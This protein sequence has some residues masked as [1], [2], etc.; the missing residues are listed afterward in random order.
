[1]KIATWNVNSVRSR[2]ERL[3]N[4][5]FRHQPDIV[6]LQELK[7]L[8]EVFPYNE[9]RAAGYFAAVHGQK[10]YNGVAVLSREEA[11]EIRCGFEDNVEDSEARLIWAR[12]GNM[13]VISVY[14]PN[15]SEIGSD[16]WHYKLA[17]LER[18]Q[19]YLIINFPDK[20]S[21]LI[22]C[23]D[24]NIARDQLDMADPPAW[25]NTV[26]YH[27][28]IV[29]PF[30]SILKGGLV[31]VFR[32]K[33]PEGKIYSW[34]DYRQLAFPRNDGLRLDYILT[35]RPLAARCTAAYV[36]RDERKGEKPSDHAPVL[37][38]FD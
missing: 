4:F 37:A 16:K 9:I 27:P 18:L 15:G 28:D 1:M 38:E 32:E 22:I 8:E 19:K 17:W 11:D 13:Q 29:R 30:E 5:L 34:W 31:D 6:C 20:D 10:T 14:V 21:P 12:F 23:G 25:E 36:D 24:T 3:T 26:L 35:S 7:C 33:N 2:L